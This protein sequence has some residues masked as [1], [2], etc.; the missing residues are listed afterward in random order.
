[1]LVYAVANI[2]QFEHKNSKWSSRLAFGN[3]DLVY[4]N[5]RIEI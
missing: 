4:C 3:R 5:R 1:V 2:W